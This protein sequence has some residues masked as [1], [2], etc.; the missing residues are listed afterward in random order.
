MTV[1]FFPPDFYLENKILAIGSKVVTEAEG[2]DGRWAQN[3]NELVDFAAGNVLACKAADE[4]G[5]DGFDH[6][7]SVE[8]DVPRHEGIHL[9]G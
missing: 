5:A 6:Q 2:V 8:H 7:I 3:A 4:A 1:Q 9:H